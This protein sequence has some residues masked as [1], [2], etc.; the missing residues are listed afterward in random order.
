MAVLPFCPGLTVEIFVNGAPLPEYDDNSDNALRTL[1]FVPREPSPPP[2]EERPEEELT[3]EELRELVKQLKEH[4]AAAVKVK[5]EAVDKRK[6]V[7]EAVEPSDSEEV[8]V[9]RSRDR[10]RHRGADDEVIVLD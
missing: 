5:K 6:R 9:V 1:G 10:K 2:L 8:T 3:P 4:K 7:D